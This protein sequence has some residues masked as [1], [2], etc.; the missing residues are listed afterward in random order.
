MN[1]PTLRSRRGFTLLE[2]IL[3]MSLML[4]VIG[5]TTEL[6]RKQSA[7]VS[8]QSGRLDAQQNSQFAISTDRARAPCGGRRRG[9]RAAAARHGQQARPH[10]QRRSRLRSTRAT[11]GSVYIN[12]DAD[13]AAVDVLRSTAP[14]TL[15]GT[16]KTYPD[17]T[18]TSSPGVPSNA[19]TISYWL[20]HDSTSSFS[21]DYILFRRVN[22]RPARRRRPR[23]RLQHGRHDLPLLQDRHARQSDRGRSVG[24]PDHPLRADPR[25]AGRHRRRRR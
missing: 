14:I 16:S 10:V 24:A 6:F 21:N 11:M 12:P 25:V 13:S 4:V 5:L 22:A 3:S 18:Y 1:A 23:H 19:E 2:M 8:T 7:S 15:P 9:R 17:T 20:S